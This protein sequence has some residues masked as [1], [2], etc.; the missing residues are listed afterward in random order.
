MTPPRAPLPRGP[1]V[2]LGLMTATTFLGP[3]LIGWVVR[4]GDRP[5]WPPDRSVEWATV[6]GTSGAV[7]GLMLGCLSL[8]FINRRAVVPRTARPSGSEP[9]PTHPTAEV[10]R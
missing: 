4:G 2:L 1:F 7:L 10:D 6:F 8:G 5:N 9:A 3:F